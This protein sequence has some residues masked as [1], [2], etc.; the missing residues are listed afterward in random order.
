MEVLSK[1][2]FSSLNLLPSRRQSSV[3]APILE[4]AGNLEV[5]QA[6][7]IEQSEWPLKTAP[8]SMLYAKFGKS[9]KKFRVHKTANPDGYAILRLE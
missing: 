1:E 3:V 7:F 2:Q 8:N 6:I 9:G 5:D 4:A